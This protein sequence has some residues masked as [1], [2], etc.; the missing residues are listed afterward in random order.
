MSRL[1]ALTSAI[2]VTAVMSITATQAFAAVGDTATFQFNLPSTAESSQNPPYP[3]VGTVTLTEVSG[4]VDFLLAPNWLDS[5]TGFAPQSFVERLNFVYEGPANP[6]FTYLSGAPIKTFSYETNSNTMDSGYKTDDQWIGIDWY[7]KNDEDRFTSNETSSWRVSGV[8]TDF[9]GTQALSN[10]KPDP[11]F[12]VISV[13]AYSLDGFTPTPSN[14]V[15]GV[16]PIPE[17]EIYAMLSI[18]LGLMGWVGR[19]RKLQTA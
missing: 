6:T 13:T 2:L 14:W 18:G 4:G 9:T 7:T 17:P 10:S 12:G 3:L 1:R 15:T 16:S 19:R 8:L 5:S 11:I